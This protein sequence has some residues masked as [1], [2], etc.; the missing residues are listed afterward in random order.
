M[1]TSEKAHPEPGSDRQDIAYINGEFVPLHEARISILDHAVL[2]GDG[3]F[4]TLMAWNGRVFKLEE[5]M[6]RLSRSLAFVGIELPIPIS[7]LQ[8]VI[9]ETVRRNELREAYIKCVVTRGE[10]GLPLLDPSG[11]K[12][13]V[14][15]LAVPYL[16]MAPADRVQR[17]LRVK[18]TAIRRPR[19][20]MLN[21]HVKS[22]NYLNLILARMEAKAAGADE[23]LLLDAG[24]HVCEAPGY[25]VFV[26][27]DGALRTPREDILDGVTRS[28]V[29]DLA[30]DMELTALVEDLDLYHLYNADEVIFSSTAG[31][32]LAVVSIDGHVIG[33]GTPGSVYAGL[34]NAYTELV[35]SATDGTEVW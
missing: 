20:D 24:G 33:S 9:V 6:R 4:E 31:G 16:S 22:L 15:V 21:A 8:E 17:G 35:S 26:Y 30:R 2:Y 10:N 25:N 27:F 32:L 14:I 18:T 11:C 34:R 5:H 13:S 1:V 3:V 28:T 29:M 19:S 7:Q 23:A 12:P